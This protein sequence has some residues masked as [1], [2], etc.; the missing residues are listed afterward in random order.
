MTT[1]L[2]SKR[3][4]VTLRRPSLKETLRKVS[5]ERLSDGFVLAAGGM[6]A[7]TG[8]EQ[9]V[10]SLRSRST[11]DFADPVFGVS[12][13][14]VVL[15]FGIVSL[16]VASFCL[17]AGRRALSLGLLVWLSAN[18]C[19]YR[20][21]LWQMGW[22]QPYPFVSY[23]SNAWHISTHASGVFQNAI[24]AYLLGG[25]VICFIALRRGAA[26]KEYLKMFCP[27]CGGHI[28]F[29]MKNLGEKT[30]CPHCQIPVTLRQPDE[31]L[32]IS[33]F[34]CHGHIEFPAHALGTK[35][36]CPHCQKDITLVEP[37]TRSG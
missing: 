11:L 14:Y 34:F 21:G 16:V 20:I 13:P 1:A 36:P 33:C 5:A 25:G 2:S 3:A 37:K 35:M 26:N 31:S 18:V 27:A 12:F 17:F 23:L 19:L 8:I 30:S 9:V 22:T 7:L 24:T 32:K 4:N 6:L 29:V 28:R 10:E 15:G